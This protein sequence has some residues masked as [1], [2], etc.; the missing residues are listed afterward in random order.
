M[1]AKDGAKDSSNDADADTDGGGRP[2]DGTPLPQP[3]LSGPYETLAPILLH[4]GA[5]FGEAALAGA[6]PPVTETGSPI[7]ADALA[8]KAAESSQAAPAAV[9]GSAPAKKKPKKSIFKAVTMLTT[10]RGGKRSDSK[11]SARDDW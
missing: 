10:P 11:S 4:P 8:S 6:A 7:A 3:Q 2:A 9:E 1:P 5:Y